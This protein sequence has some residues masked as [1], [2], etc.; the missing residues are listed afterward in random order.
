MNE[1][2]RGFK[3]CDCAS[4][5]NSGGHAPCMQEICQTFFFA[6][7]E[8][9]DEV[10]KANGRQGKRHTEE[11]LHGQSLTKWKKAKNAKACKYEYKGN[12]NLLN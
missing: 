10:M 12:E 5:E 4:E 8:C 11:N 3:A 7:N 9:M 6:S 2:S 1:G